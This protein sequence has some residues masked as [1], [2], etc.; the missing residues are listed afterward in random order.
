MYASRSP[1]PRS[2]L[3]SI[4]CNHRTP[5]TPNSVHSRQNGLQNTDP[6]LNLSVSSRISRALAK[7]IPTSYFS[8]Q[9][10]WYIG[11]SNNKPQTSPIWTPCSRCKEANACSTSGR[12]LQPERSRTSLRP[13]SQSGSYNNSSG[14]SISLQCLG[15][16]EN[17]S[18]TRETQYL[19]LRK[20]GTRCQT[21]NLYLLYAIKACRSPW[22]DTTS[23]KVNYQQQQCQ[24][25]TDSGTKSFYNK[26]RH[27]SNPQWSIDCKDSCHYKQ[28]RRIWTSSHG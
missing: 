27:H 14:W 9:G 26:N 7:P 21:S 28:T 3:A 15:L 1:S 2:T 22:T 12:L 17:L 6:N 19:I 4:E 13:T 11:A 16:H 10:A 25:I 8:T 5:K 23:S 18:S 20:R 24:R